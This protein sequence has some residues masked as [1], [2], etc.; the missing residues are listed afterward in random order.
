[1][2]CASDSSVRVGNVGEDN[3]LGSEGGLPFNVSWRRNSSAKDPGTGFTDAT[4][5][6]DVASVTVEDTLL[7]ERDRLR[8]S[9]SRSSVSVMETSLWS[10]VSSEGA[11][12]IPLDVGGVPKSPS[13]DRGRSFGR[14]E[15]RMLRGL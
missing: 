10:P 15:P 13:C 4:D 6:I 9:L 8:L 14:G 3:G 12:S 7:V 11:V 1:M 2:S 5:V